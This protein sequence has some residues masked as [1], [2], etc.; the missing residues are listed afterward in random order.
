M[1]AKIQF[2]N[3]TIDLLSVAEERLLLLILVA[4]LVDVEDHHMLADIFHEDVL[5]LKLLVVLNRAGSHRLVHDELLD[6]VV[7]Y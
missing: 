6:Y 2:A 4:A 7:H 3:F 1:A 5:E